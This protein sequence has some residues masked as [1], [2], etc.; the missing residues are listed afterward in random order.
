MRASLSAELLKLRKRPAT[1]VV[2]AVFVLIS[3]FAF[4]FPYLSYRRDAV[5]DGA[6]STEELLEAALPASLVPSALSAWPLLGG[7]VALVFGVLL[8]GSEYSWDTLKTVLTQRPGRLAT[9][10][11]KVAAAALLTGAGVVASTAVDAL[12]SLAVAAA[13]HRAVAWPPLAGLAADPGAD[14]P[15]LGRADRCRDRHPQPLP[16]RYQRGSRGR[17]ARRTDRA[18]GP[19]QPRRD[20][21]GRRRPR[22][23]G[24]RRVPGRAGRRDRRG[25][26][27]ARRHLN[28]GRRDRRS[29]GW[30]PVAAT[31]RRP[32]VAGQRRRP[33]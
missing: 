16:S 10:A 9:L 18:T 27:P 11:G 12:A 3:L 8:A 24:G 14:D 13:E 20:R 33:R 31:H 2:G 6:R 5:L 1:W 22:R 21:C 32:P 23:A 26:A 19:G 7:A 29:G 25:G 17:R 15:C 28:V 4:G 30:P